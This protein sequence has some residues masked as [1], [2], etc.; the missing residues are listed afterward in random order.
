MPDARHR[1]SDVLQQPRRRLHGLAQGRQRHRRAALD[2]A[3]L[4]QEIES[5][6]YRGV[7][8]GLSGR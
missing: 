4:S 6:S 8:R 2:L 5:A 1:L 3:A 7:A